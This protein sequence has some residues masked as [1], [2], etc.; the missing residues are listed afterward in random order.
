ML[1]QRRSG[2]KPVVTRLDG[3]S[4]PSPGCSLC[5]LLPV[6]ANTARSRGKEYDLRQP[7]VSRGYGRIQETSPSCWR[8]VFPFRAKASSS[9]PL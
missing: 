1:F 9:A 8:V 3:R 5:A 6:A 2:R 4:W 7:S